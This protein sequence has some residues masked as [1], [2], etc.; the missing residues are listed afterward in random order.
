VRQL[1]IVGLA[2]VGRAPASPADL[3]GAAFLRELGGIAVQRGPSHAAGP[4][5]FGD[6]GRLPVPRRERATV[7]PR[8]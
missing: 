4:D 8:A 3:D 6:V 7:C 2:R 5:E 1:R